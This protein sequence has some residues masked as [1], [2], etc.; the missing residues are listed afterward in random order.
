MAMACA[1]PE[2]LAKSHKTPLYLKFS[3]RKNSET[4]EHEDDVNESN[5]VTVSS[6]TR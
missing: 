1:E 6:N 2:C 4:P 3:R 5:E